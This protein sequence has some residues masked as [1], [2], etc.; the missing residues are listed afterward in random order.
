MKHLF[1]IKKDIYIL[2]TV[3]TLTPL[4]LFS[5]TITDTTLVMSDGI[6]L[7]A[8][9][10]MPEM[11]PPAE[12][13]PAILLVHG[14]GGSK[15]NNRSLALDFAREGYAATAYSVRG[16]GNSGGEFEFFTAPRILDDLRECIAFTGQLDN[17]NRD[18]LAVL[19]GS[20][21]GMHAWN[22]A[23]YDMGVRTAVS[24]IANGRVEENWLEN[25]ALNYTFAL[26]TLSPNVRFDPEVM[27]ILREARE[28]G[29]F[30]EVRSFLRTH[31]TS[32]L[33]TNVS[34][35]TA[36]FVSYRDGF[37]NQNAA[38]RQ[39]SNIPAPKR[40]VLYPG[41][42]SLPSDPS[43][44]N[45]ILDVIDR[46]LAY[47][48]KDRQEY[49]TVVSPDSAVVFFDGSSG[50]RAVYAVDES[51]QWL[52]PGLDIPINM[53]RMNIYL[54]E[55]SL[56]FTP[57]LEEGQRQISYITSLGSE[58]MTFRTRTLEEDIRILPPPGTAQLRVLGTGSQYQ[59]NVLLYER[60]ADGT[61]IPLC[62]GHWQDS[63]P[64]VER[65]LRFE[66]TGLLHTVKA[67]ST[68]EAIVHGG[69]ALLPDMSNNF[70]NFVLGP[71]ASSQNTLFFGG[72]VPSRISL[73]VENKG[74]TGV[75]ATAAPTGVQ[76]HPVHPNPVS[77]AGTVSF[78]LR[79]AMP[80]RL[81]VHDVLG[82]QVLTLVDDGLHPGRFDVTLPVHGLPNG[83][84]F[85]RL[86]TATTTHT[87]RITVMR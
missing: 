41:G 74:A 2:L 63:E 42:H 26:A 87:Q 84:Y 67:G 68:I 59:M 4:L 78:E 40:I 25:G 50:E 17:V 65:S 36:I 57:P 79:Q 16:Q 7:D 19:G 48:L 22:A 45:Y 71:A 66:L 81:T 56:H 12:G 31:S 76:L 32:T 15:N 8:F 39:F 1:T 44:E 3:F 49:V 6:E 62:R 20:Q 38:L 54:E 14:F 61:R 69:V 37:F 83:V 46:W 55:D 60:K 53:R 47:W 43:Q 58:V 51:E 85:V 70:G 18:R 27:T 80:V 86:G 34:T 9:Y 21:G 23:A 5:Q 30:T 10:V 11:A 52:A 64:G 82:R 77:T 33:E 75:Q 24:I 35:P 29:D 73:Y 28:S 72:T 13:H